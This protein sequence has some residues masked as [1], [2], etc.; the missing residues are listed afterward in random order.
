MWG[1]LWEGEGLHVGFVVMHWLLPHLIETRIGLQRLRR[2][3]TNAL[4]LRNLDGNKAM[5]A[6]YPLV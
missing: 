3:G 1:W 2:S 6:E 4:H 5:G